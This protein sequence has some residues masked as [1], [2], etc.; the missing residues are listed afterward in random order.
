MEHILKIIVAIIVGWV[1]YIWWS[2]KRYRA[3]ADE[4]K[5]LLVSDLPNYEAQET[6]LSAV[7][8]SHYPRHNEAFEKLLI[9]TPK[10]KHQ[11]LMKLWGKYTEIYS[12]LVQRV[13]L[14]LLWL[15]FLILTLSQAWKM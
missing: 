7:V 4:F 9:Y 13:F 15:S 2:K 14:V 10:R 6:T 11:V 5:E 3:K 1:G 8:L 12:F